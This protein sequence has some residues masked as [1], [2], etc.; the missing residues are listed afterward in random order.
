VKRLY[1]LRHA[2]SSW[3]DPGLEDHDRP[4]ARR[5]R[6]ACKKLSKHIRREGMKPGLV[7][8]SSARRALETL[9]LIADALG[10]VPVKVEDGLYAADSEYLLARLRALPESVSSALLVGHNPGLQDLAAALASGAA[11]VAEAFPTGGLASFELD[12]P[13]PELGPGGAELVAYVAPR[14]LP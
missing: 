12:R 3:D 10:D 14:E 13:W 8:C 2:K 9:E 5:G 7:L 4:L 6:K 11:P 1:L